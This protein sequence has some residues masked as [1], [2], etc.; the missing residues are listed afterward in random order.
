[1]KASVGDRI[2]MASNHVD[3]PVRDGRIVEVRHGDGSPPYLVEWSDTGATGLVFPGPDAHVEALPS[4]P[5]ETWSG[6]SPPSRLKKWRVEVDVIEAG[7]ETTA[8]VMLVE[9]CPAPLGADGHARRNPH[10]LQ[11][12]DIGDEVA[13]ARALHRLADGLLEMASADIATAEG[14]PVSLRGS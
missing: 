7:D 4:Q 2:V 9:G 1:M 5:G 14:H 3:G 12:A 10:D 6:A 13:V 11:A 8:H